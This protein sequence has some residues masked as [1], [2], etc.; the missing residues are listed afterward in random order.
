MTSLPGLPYALDHEGE[1]GVDA[2]NYEHHFSQEAS[3]FGP[4][5]SSP[6]CQSHRQSES[7][8]PARTECD[9]PFFFLGAILIGNRGWIG[10]PN[11]FVR[12]G[13]SSSRRRA[14]P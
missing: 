4:H 9:L 1:A 7:H 10:L 2:V 13:R 11:Y 6:L 14:I 8:A 12:L 3:R 5:T